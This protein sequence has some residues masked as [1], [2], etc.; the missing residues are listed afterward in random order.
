MQRIIR[1]RSYGDLAKYN[2]PHSVE[3]TIDATVV[4]RDGYVV[5][6]DV[7]GERLLGVL[8]VLEQAKDGTITRAA[9]VPH[10]PAFPTYEVTGDKI[11]G[12]ATKI[13]PLESETAR[14]H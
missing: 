9:L 12:V 14:R 6:A 2:L 5:C 13:R 1:H 4:P 11:L 10:N 7:D 8:R 3:V